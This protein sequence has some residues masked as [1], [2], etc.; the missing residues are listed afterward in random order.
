[1]RGIA[2]S[3]AEKQTMKSDYKTGT[4]SAEKNAASTTEELTGAGAKESLL[5]TA[6]RNE[7]RAAEELRKTQKKLTE[8]TGYRAPS[9]YLLS[10]GIPPELAALLDP[11]RPYSTAASGGVTGT[12]T[13]SND[14]TRGPASAKND[15]RAFAK[16]VMSG[17]KSTGKPLNKK[18]PLGHP[19][20]M[21][22]PSHPI[23]N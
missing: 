1:M 18:G 4:V 21:V 16:S 13:A 19:L 8:N 17:K 14:V 9:S 3:P 20:S 2:G 10:K 6:V 11:R 5:L 15:L 22:I 12:R 23:A 7:A